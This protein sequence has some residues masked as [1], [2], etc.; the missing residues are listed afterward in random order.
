MVLTIVQVYV[1]ILT[2]GLGALVSEMSGLAAVEAVAL[3]EADL[4]HSG[5]DAMVLVQ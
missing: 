4:A 2:E 5:D 3:A 1:G